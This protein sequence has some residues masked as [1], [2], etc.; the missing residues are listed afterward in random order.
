MEME[1]NRAREETAIAEERVRELQKM[2]LEGQHT[3]AYQ[4]NLIQQL[5]DRLRRYEEWHARDSTTTAQGTHTTDN[6]YRIGVH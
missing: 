1:L 6:E 5:H 2:C 3:I 4:D